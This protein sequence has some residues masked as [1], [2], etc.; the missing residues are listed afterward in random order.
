[1][2]MAVNRDHHHDH[3]PHHADGVVLT[4]MMIVTGA[5]PKIVHLK[6]T[7]L[8]QLPR[9]VSMMNTIPTAPQM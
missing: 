6:Q 2:M 4:V 8:A 1:M 5:T 9:L 7:G 3:D